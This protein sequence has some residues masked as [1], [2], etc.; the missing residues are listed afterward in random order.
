M[1]HL[2]S[3]VTLFHTLLSIDEKPTD[4]KEMEN[5]VALDEGDIALL[6]TYASASLFLLSFILMQSPNKDKLRYVLR[7]VP[8]Q[9]RFFIPLF[10]FA[11]T[12]SNR[13][14]DLTLRT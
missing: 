5:I 7:S 14:R 12:S 6:K 2:L 1:D 11:F 13:V 10:K 4:D 9:A 8:N 3:S